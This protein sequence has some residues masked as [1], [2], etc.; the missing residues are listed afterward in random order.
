MLIALILLILFGGCASPTG[1]AVDQATS[2][3]LPNRLVGTW[4]RPIKNH[5]ETTEGIRFDDNGR[6]GL[7]GIHTMHGLEWKRENDDLIVTTNTGRYPEPFETR[8]SI[9]TLTDTTLIL[10]GDKGY[11][12]GSWRRDDTSA[13]RITGQVAYRERIALPPDAAIH[14]T[15][16]DVS[17]QA[18]PAT[19]IASQVIPTLGCQVPIPFALYYASGDID[20]KRTYQ[21]RAA[22]VMDGQRRFLTTQAYPVL[23]RGNPDHI[24]ITLQGVQPKQPLSTQP[25]SKTLR[26]EDLH[27]P[28]TY[29]GQLERPSGNQSRITLNLYSNR[30]FFLRK[31]AETPADDTLASGHDHGRWYLAHGGRQLILIGR[32]EAPYKLAV[33]DSETFRLLSLNGSK[34]RLPHPIDLTRRDGLDPFEDPVPM[35]GMFRYMADAA[36]FTECLTEASFPV[37]QENDYLALERAYLAHRQTAGE[38]L[39]TTLTGHLGQ[40][41]KMEGDGVQTVIVVDRFDTIQRHA[42]CP[43]RNALARLQNTYWKLTELYG[44]T[45][46]FAAAGQGEPHLMLRPQEY[47]M[48]GF[49]GCNG[50]FGLYRLDGNRLSFENMGATMKAC[51]LEPNLEKIFF[52][53]LTATEHFKIFGEMLEL[54]DGRNAVARFEAV[55]F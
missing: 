53:A 9:K 32:A 4:I 28:A 20:P 26:V 16:E 42:T 25:H 48:S 54:Y 17:R 15:L 46:Q 38:P 13:G 1:M 29:S 21:V 23:T 39:F 51:P 19:Y 2:L 52:R 35:T 34:D 47:Q 49:S 45:I 8:L 27:L 24:E 44:K 31:P 12:R 36:L 6:F 33:K 7:I 30:I 41:P 22:I 43:M 37:A 5:P 55:Y 50:F 40:R 11:F 10:E 18:A 3:E 14:L